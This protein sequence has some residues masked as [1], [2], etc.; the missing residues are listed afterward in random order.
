MPLNSGDGRGRSPEGRKSRFVGEEP[1]SP[2]LQRGEH[3]TNDVVTPS[4][5]RVAVT[6]APTAGNTKASWETVSA[7]DQLRRHRGSPQRGG[8]PECFPCA[9]ASPGSAQ[10]GTSCNPVA[11]RHP[12]LPATSF[13]VLDIAADSNQ[14]PIEV[15]VGPP[16]G[17]HFIP[18]HPGERTHCHDRVQAVPLSSPSA[19]GSKPLGSTS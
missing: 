13:G 16:E 15:N 2:S 12:D 11:L 10:S 5:L 4:G 8:A 18:A 6:P 17:E 1:R 7:T 3:V 9:E 14:A 19:K